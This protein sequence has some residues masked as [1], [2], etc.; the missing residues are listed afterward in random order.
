MHFSLLHTIPG[1]ALQHS[2]TLRRILPMWFG[3]G[4]PRATFARDWSRRLIW[5]ACAGSG[6]AISP[7]SYFDQFSRWPKKSL[8]IYAKYDLTFLPEFSRQVAEQF[9]R[10]NLDQ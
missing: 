9:A 10:H 8:I 7:M 1:F 5:N 3:T 2:I 4:N 6:G